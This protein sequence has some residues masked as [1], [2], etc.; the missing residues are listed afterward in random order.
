MRVEKFGHACVRVSKGDSAVVI[1]PG[2][3]TPEPD[4]WRD[5]D[6][7]LVTHEHFDHFD[8]DGIAALHADCPHV[9][10]ITPSGVARRL[11]TVDIEAEV[12]R[13][14]EVLDVAGF[15][16]RGVGTR[17]HPSHPDASPVD[18]VG[19]LLDE[20]LLHPGDALP[21]ITVPV[22]LV[23]AQAPWL[24]VPDLVAHLR[25]TTPQRTL[26][27]HDGLMNQWGLRVVDD[28][29]GMEC[30]R[31]GTEVRRLRIGETVDV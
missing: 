20:W 17:H 3:M 30:Q 4:A 31:S 9:R 2:L 19:Y 23:A 10:V 7:V 25:R 16:I 18:N 21:D 26:A 13:D 5:V 1:D 29:L 22:L 28:V 6:A 27:I 12:L 11:R 14:G 24:T 15:Q 8:P